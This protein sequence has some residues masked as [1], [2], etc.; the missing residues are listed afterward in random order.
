MVISLVEVTG[1]REKEKDKAFKIAVS[2]YPTIHTSMILSLS[3]DQ[4][5]PSFE[6]EASQQEENH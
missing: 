1:K 4:T 3:A 2:N 5:R 6:A